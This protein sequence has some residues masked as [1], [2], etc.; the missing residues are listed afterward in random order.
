MSGIRRFI[1]IF[2]LSEEE[3]DYPNDWVENLTEKSNVLG[4]PQQKRSIAS[5]FSL[6]EVPPLEPEPAPEIPLNSEYYYGPDRS[7]V[8]YIRI[9]K[10]NPGIQRRRKKVAESM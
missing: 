4:C 6:E 3:E 8:I 7:L 9:C 10:L 1:K 5:P 2:N